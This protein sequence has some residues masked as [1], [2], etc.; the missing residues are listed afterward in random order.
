MMPERRWVY[1]PAEIGDEDVDKT[2]D[3]D[4]EGVEGKAFNIHIKR[5]EGGAVGVEMAT[6][7]R[8]DGV[9]PRRIVKM[10]VEAVGPKARKTADEG[11]GLGDLTQVTVIDHQWY[12]IP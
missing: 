9:E 10:E 6:F 2:V 4:G 5:Q 12:T 1:D 11:R 8:E 7:Q 3:V